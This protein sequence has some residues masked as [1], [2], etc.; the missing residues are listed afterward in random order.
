MFD[1][2]WST[3][4]KTNNTW[5]PI[6]LTVFMFFVGWFLG[7]WQPQGSPWVTGGLPGSFPFVMD[8]EECPKCGLKKRSVSRVRA[9]KAEQ[10]QKED[11]DHIDMC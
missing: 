1:K 6:R 3:S 8:D 11:K 5:I 7:A 4:L 9:E 10:R 2:K